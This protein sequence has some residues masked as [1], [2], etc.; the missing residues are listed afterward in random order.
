ME[1]TVKIKNTSL[2]TPTEEPEYETETNIFHVDPF[3]L[4]KEKKAKNVLRDKYSDTMH[5]LHLN[6]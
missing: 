6:F 3:R 4:P 2:N 1:K 5:Y